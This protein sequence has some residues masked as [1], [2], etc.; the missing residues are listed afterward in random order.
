[1]DNARIAIVANSGWNI[2]N[3]RIPLIRRLMESGHRVDIIS[4]DDVYLHK[5]PTDLRASITALK[6]LSPKRMNPWGELELMLELWKA[7]KSLR[8]DLVLQFTIKPNLYGSIAARMLGIPA[9]SN[10]TGLGF[11]ATG[12]HPLRRMLVAA[13]RRALTSN[14]A[15]VFHNA[16]DLHW[17]AG[18]SPKLQKK[19]LV[20]P[21]SGV[22]PDKFRRKTKDRADG[23]FVFLFASRL[24]AEK[25]I[26]E[27]LKASLRVLA[28]REDVVCRIAGSGTLPGD[29]RHPGMQVLGPQD[30]VWALLDGADA[31]VLPSHRE[32]MP[33]ALLEAMSMELPCI[34]ADVPGC[35]QAVDEGRVGRLVP[36][37]DAT[38][39]AEAMLQLV[40]TPQMARLEMGRAARQRVLDHYA[41]TPICDAYE[42]LL[43]QV[44]NQCR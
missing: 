21:G 42:R 10:L 31:F 38:A 43:A 36:P 8:P 29:Y 30:D 44:I 9:V 3:Y 22:D 2:Y 12:S 17:F 25:G 14:A 27:F 32:G 16:D 23:T 18:S 13:Y 39:L 28:T 41:D 24:E 34:V 5:L 11:V 33:R 4:P 6:R 15:V 37:G 40:S 35:R 7:Y 1:M 20:I 19:S 26:A